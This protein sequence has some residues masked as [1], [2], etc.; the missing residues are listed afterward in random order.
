MIF[1]EQVVN[2]ANGKELFKSYFTSWYDLYLK[3]QE[4]TE[5][6]EHLSLG[7]KH[8]SLKYISAY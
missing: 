6:R 4:I 8:N 1:G 2:S 7:G 3:K 5:H